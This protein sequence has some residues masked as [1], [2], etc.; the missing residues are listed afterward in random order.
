MD[1]QSYKVNECG[2]LIYLME[3][4]MEATTSLYHGKLYHMYKVEKKT[5]GVLGLKGK[6]KCY[7]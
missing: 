7:E 5:S 1:N 2:I 6:N 3:A 4:S